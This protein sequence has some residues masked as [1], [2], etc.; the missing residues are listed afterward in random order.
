[1]MKLFSVRSPRPKY[2]AR[3]ALI[4]GLLA[5]SQQALAQDDTCTIQR[6]SLCDGCTVQRRVNVQKDTGCRFQT[7]SDSVILDIQT[8]VRPK[9]GIFGKSNPSAQAYIPAKGYV[10]TDYFEFVMVYELR[11]QRATTRV[12]NLVTVTAD[13]PLF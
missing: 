13:K 1:M 9:H 10:G 8:T 3:L 2:N 7:M 6:Y 5:L 4:A 11:G 12:Q